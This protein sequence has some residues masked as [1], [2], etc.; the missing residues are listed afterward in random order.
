MS[1]AGAVGI[2]EWYDGESLVAHPVRLFYMQGCEGDV[3]FVC[4]RRGGRILQHRKRFV[5][6]TLNLLY[7]WGSN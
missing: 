2:A 5:T 6:D 7:L 1:D 4:F 3:T